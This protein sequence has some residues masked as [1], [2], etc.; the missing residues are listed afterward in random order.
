VTLIVNLDL[1]V[2]K[3]YLLTDEVSRSNRSKIRT[4]T[5]H[6]HTFCC[7]DLDLYQTTLIYELDVDILK[8]HEYTKNEGLQKLYRRRDRHN[9][10]RA[11]ERLI[12]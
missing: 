1:D 8:T 7:C 4:K 9:K 6:V 5:V 10:T 3:E 11:V 2:L 12:F